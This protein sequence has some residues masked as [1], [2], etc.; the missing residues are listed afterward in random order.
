G[1]PLAGLRALAGHCGAG[2]ALAFHDAARARR[3]AGV[4]AFGGIAARP[5][6]RRRVAA[7]QPVGLHGAG[8]GA[9]EVVWR[10][11]A[12]LAGVLRAG[13]RVAA[14][15]IADAICADAGA[16]GRALHAGA[17]GEAGI[18]G[19]RVAGAGRVIARALRA[20]AVH[21]RA[22]DRREHAD[23]VAASPGLQA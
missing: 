7:G 21:R 9:R 16:E 3:R 8:L 14:A 17:A 22:A 19:R 5:A 18:D 11:D 15:G 10:A 1:I 6:D 2:A 4:R 12:G 20:F 13:A 23:V